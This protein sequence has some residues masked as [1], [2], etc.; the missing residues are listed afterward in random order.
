MNASQKWIVGM[1]AI[2]LVAIGFEAGYDFGYERGQKASQ[3]KSTSEFDAATRTT[4][5]EIARE[6]TAL[7]SRAADPLAMGTTNASE[8]FDR[9]GSKAEAQYKA[10]NVLMPVSTQYMVGTTGPG[11]RTTSIVGWIKPGE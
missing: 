3:D 6:R 11:C 5:N 4:F 7:A 2:V 1:I 9:Y 8:A 10:L